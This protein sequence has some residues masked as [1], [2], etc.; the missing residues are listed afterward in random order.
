MRRFAPVTDRI[1]D[2][3]GH[4]CVGEPWQGP[5][6]ITRRRFPQPH[7]KQLRFRLAIELARRGRFPAL[8]AL[9]SPFKAFRN[10]AFAEILDRLLAAVESIGHPDIWP[11]WPIGIRLEQNLSA[12]KLLR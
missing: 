8:L 10:Q 12:T 7:G 6:S 4:K 1:D 9:Q 2:F 3:Q 5:V 11:S